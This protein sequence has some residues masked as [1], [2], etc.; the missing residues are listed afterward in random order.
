M[1]MNDGS[2]E[3]NWMKKTA[4]TNLEGG[5]QLSMTDSA[6]ISRNAQEKK[7]SEKNRKTKIFTFLFQ[8]HNTYT[9]SQ[10][11]HVHS[12]IGTYAHTLSL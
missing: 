6:T 12:P 8:K 9:H 5:V 2:V 4:L 10:H 7:K 3:F 11:T 1:F